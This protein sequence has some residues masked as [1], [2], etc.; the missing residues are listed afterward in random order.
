MKNLA[1]AIDGPAGAGKSTI[2]KKIS[3]IK[4]L[5]YIDTGAMYRA[6]TLKLLKGNIPFNDDNSIIEVLKNTKIEI[7]NNSIFLDGEKVD[8]EIRSPIVSENVSK[9]AALPYV[10][11]ELVKKQQEIAKYNNVIMDGRDIG[12]KVLPDAKYKF[13]LTA[14]IKE[15]AKRRYEELIQKGYKC[16]LEDIIKELSQRDKLDSERKHDPLKKADDAILIDTTGKS[17]EDVIEDILTII[18]DS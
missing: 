7:H 14:D 18:K 9:I 15:R 1:I 5:T 17:I 4:N 11:R 2:A 16:S 3:K 8:K 13:Y 6:F 10:R 12:T